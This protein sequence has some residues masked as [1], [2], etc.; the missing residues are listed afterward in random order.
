MWE[1]PLKTERGQAYYGRF[2]TW[3]EE[4]GITDH[5]DPFL[6]RPERSLVLIPKALQP[7]A[8]RVDEK[9]YTF[10]GACQ[11]D[12]S[13]E[14]GWTRPEGAEK[15]GLASLGVRLHQ[16][17]GVLP[18]VCPGLRRA[19]RRACTPCSR[20]AGTSTPPSWATYRTRWKCA[21][22]CRSWRS[23]S[24]PTCSSP[25]RGAGGS[26]EGPGDRHADDRRTAG[27]G[28]VRQ[29]RHAPGPRR[30]PGRLPT[31]EAGA[32]ALRTAA[33]ALL[34]DPEVAGR[35]NKIQAEMA[36]E[37]GTRRAAD[38]IEAELAAARG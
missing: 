31:E 24:R 14:G 7:N 19:A 13:A 26:Q 30:C 25:T 4:N 28:P 27:G 15:V 9:A 3:L 5:P 34:D 1:K 10:V 8:D 32:E 23:S 29:R 35:L 36:Q 38:L 6:G 11:G 17:A 18:G 12:R 33:L 16:A 2:R 20:S 21:R 37:G 22:G